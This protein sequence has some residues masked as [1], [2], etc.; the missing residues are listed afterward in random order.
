M[1]PEQGSESDIPNGT[2]APIESLS[3][4]SINEPTPE[5]V[6]TSSRMDRA[7]KKFKSLLHP[8]RPTQSSKTE[9]ISSE[10]QK[11]LSPRSQMAIPVRQ[12]RT[13]GGL[14]PRGSRVSR[15]DSDTRTHVEYGQRPWTTKQT[16]RDIMQN[17]LDAETQIFVNKLISAT[18]DINRLD[19][20]DPNLPTTLDRYAYILFLF[21]K[22]LSDIT[23]QAQKE[24]KKYLDVFAHSGLPIEKKFIKDEGIDM[25]TIKDAIEPINETRPQIYYQVI[26]TNISQYQQ[27][28]QWVSFES[29]QQP[30][31]SQTVKSS[32]GENTGFRYQVRAVRIE[33]SGGGFDSKL[34]TIYKSTKVGQLYLR[35]K[36]GEGIKMSL[37]HMLRHGVQAKMRSRFV[38]NGDQP[39]HERVWQHKAYIDQK[40]II[41]QKGI[42]IDLPSSGQAQS[43]SFTLIPLENADMEFKR[44]FLSNIDPR[45]KNKGLA[46]NC[47]EYSTTRFYY[48]TFPL[49]YSID[50]D[51]TY[52][53]KGLP[54]GVSIDSPPSQQFVQGLNVD[55][56][57][58][59]DFK[60]LFSYNFFDSSLLKGRD[61]NDLE[62]STAN[63]EVQ[64]FWLN[65]VSPNL[66]EQL[67][68]KV[69]NKPDQEYFV[70]EFTALERILTGDFNPGNLNDND[71]R[72]A[73]T[74]NALQIFPSIVN[75][76]KDAKNI[77]MYVNHA[78]A[79]KDTIQ[80]LEKKGYHI[81]T[82]PVGVGDKMVNGLNSI[83]SGTYQFLTYKDVIEEVNSTRIDT[84]KEAERVK[85]SEEFFQESVQELQP[86]IEKAGLSWQDFNIEPEAYYYEVINPNQESAFD[87]EYDEESDKFHLAIR[88]DLLNKI[89]RTAEVKEYWK[90]VLQIDLLALYQRHERFSDENSRHIASQEV[91]QQLMEKTLHKGLEDVDILPSQFQYKTTSADTLQ[92]INNFVTEH[93]HL[94]EQLLGLSAFSE[95]SKFNVGLD[96]MEDVLD[97]LS[98]MPP[99]FKRKTQEIMLKRVIVQNGT[100]GYFEYS[101]TGKGLEFHKVDLNILT[102]IDSV[103]GHPIYKIGSKLFLPYDFPNG[104]VIKPEGNSGSMFV[105]YGNQLLEYEKP[106]NI[107]IFN[108]YTFQSHPVIFE[109]G[110]FV[111]KTESYT[112]P[113]ESLQQLKSGYENNKVLLP[114]RE[115]L[116][117]MEFLEGVNETTLPS[118]YGKDEWD[119][120]IRVFEDIVQNHLDAMIGGTIELRYE[121][122]RGKER[123]WVSQEDLAQD[124]VIVGFMVTDKGLGYNPNDIGI[125]GKSSKISP[126]F[127]GKYGEGQKLIAASAIRNGLELQYSSVSNYQGARYRWN[128]KAVPKPD[129]YYN[130][131]GI[132]TPVDLVVFDINSKPIDD[133]DSYTSSTIL[134]LPEGKKDVT[135]WK[136]W[137]EVIDPRIKDKYG[138]GGLAR[139]VIPLMRNNSESMIDLGYMKILLNRPGQLYENGL[140][141]RDN[142]STVC[143]YDVPTIVTSRDRNSYSYS[144]LDKYILSAIY[145]CPDGQYSQ[146]LL[147]YLKSKYIQE[148]INNPETSIRESDLHLGNTYNQY[149]RNF[150]PTQALW[151]QAF[152]SQ[153]GAYLINSEPALRARIVKN[154]HSLKS[155]STAA[156][157]HQLQ[158]EIQSAQIALTNSSHLPH[159]RVLKVKAT[160]YDTL[161]MIFPTVEE[162]TSKL[163]EQEIQVPASINQT[164]HSIV[165]ASRDVIDKMSRT[166]RHN[167]FYLCLISGDTPDSLS[168]DVHKQELDVINQLKNWSKPELAKNPNKVFVSPA[169][170]GYLGLASKDRIG[171]NEY[172]LI[173]DDLKEIPAIARHELLHKIYSL[174]DYSPEFIILLLEL[175]KYNASN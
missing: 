73:T 103:D 38:I 69:L 32:N 157:I 175:A 79:H 86:I 24:L 155:V 57:N 36:F 68:K 50:A 141:I 149:F 15:L 144:L 14:L 153:F 22:G 31:Y 99:D 166:I 12:T 109:N 122:T 140:L 113:D 115:S 21:R 23:P 148:L 112:D 9:D 78:N 87:L 161:S 10:Q 136:Q 168:P 135:T 165:S 54:C 62:G 97:S 124:D 2:Q 131:V 83:H 27:P 1:K 7:V 70:P 116:N 18:V 56:E 138:E 43:G 174:P 105:V 152:K 63:G 3:T 119:N 76:R 108:T 61:R 160:D 11:E 130:K 80:S 164:L 137:L 72:A 59:D 100:A 143:G 46:A 58:V 125:M 142:I 151:T 45:V 4:P 129:T 42:Q 91:A 162:Y 170:A 146:T 120:P 172:L 106:G 167:P 132:L 127:A 74:I 169:N 102:P 107:D 139:Y 145:T 159:E 39:A 101:A 156:N 71:T 126:I 82:I 53:F 30:Q 60:P 84:N 40:G 8:R 117:E 123:I 20:D 29:L 163:S 90:R 77:V 37:A 110:G 51:Y 65:V 5:H 85:I 89:L 47:L 26:D 121:I 93:P 118:E 133:S 17:H 171:F 75:A 134:R 48:P 19:N 28:T 33:D 173:S 34:S 128:G 52:H 104:S 88:P 16:I 49:D 67:S 94:H 81:I 98:S 13:V 158:Q 6:E 154:F 66:L 95:I 147:A 44:D 55:T 64:N 150:I 114:E 41:K 35:G 96:H 92:V 111:V 25:E